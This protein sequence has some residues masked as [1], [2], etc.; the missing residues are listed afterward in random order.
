MLKQPAWAAAISSSGFVP[1]S[2]PNRIPAEYGALFNAPLSVEIVP[3][4]SGPPPCHTAS[5][6]R[7]IVGIV[8]PFRVSII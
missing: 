1:L 8:Y 6:L 2:S 4:P 5:A 7:L 3:F